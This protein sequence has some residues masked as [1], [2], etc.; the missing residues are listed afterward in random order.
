MK[1]H[2]LRFKKDQKY[3]FFDFETCG[4]NLGSELNKPWQ[5]AFITIENEKIVD[6]AD[7]WLKW[8]EL[9][10][11]AGAAKVTGWTQKK[12]DEKA[13][14]PVAPLQHFEKYLYDDTYIKVGHNILG[15]D[16]YLHGIYRRLLKLKPDYS[17]INNLLD[18]LCLARALNGDIKLQKGEDR[19]HWQYKMLSI[20]GA[21]GKNRLIDLCKQFSIKFNAQKLHD[22]LYDIEKNYEVFKK[23]LW[24]VEI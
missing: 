13:V 10:V 18:T 15:F 16:V 11:S 6:K 17:Y 23:L 7:Y 2:L 5:L 24:A 12:H 20:R 9:N 1:E 21:K 8:P 22:A 14:D 3:M 4:L 19:L